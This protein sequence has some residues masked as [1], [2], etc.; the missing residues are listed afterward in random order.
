MLQTGFLSRSS[1]LELDAP[2][3]NVPFNYFAFA[4]ILCFAGF[5]FSLGLHIGSY[6]TSA[7]QL[8]LP[9]FMLWLFQTLNSK[10]RFLIIALS[11]LL[12][13]LLMLENILLKPAF[14]RQ[15]DSVA[16]RN[17]YNYVED[18]Q[19]VVNS[20][21]VTSALI[22]AGMLPVDSGQTEYYYSIHPYADNTLL[23]PDFE[24]IRENGIAYRYS[25]QEAVKN[26]QFDRIFTTNEYGNLIALELISK[27]YT[28][29]DTLTID[30]LQSHQTW[31]I[32]VWEPQGK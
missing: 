29:V 13:N 22:E 25:I 11:L 18:S 9:L 19:H 4:F 14:L 3:L 15:S 5:V 17:L 12:I 28:Q 24:T 31:T 26:R 1:F 20:P 27:Y 8:V 10:N 2:L 16:W 21:V 6:M 30:M 23:G 32:G 7:Y